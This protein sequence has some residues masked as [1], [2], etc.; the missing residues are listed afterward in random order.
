MSVSRSLRVLVAAGILAIPVSTL[1][2]SPDMS[3]LGAG[4]W[5][6]RG[7]VP[8]IPTGGPGWAVLEQYADRVLPPPNISDTDQSNPANII[9][10][11]K[12][13]YYARTGDGRYREE[14]IAACE[15]V[16]GTEVKGTTLELGRKLISYVLAAD[17]VGLPPESDRRFRE[18]LV[19]VLDEPLSDGRSLRQTHEERPN[20]W[21]TLAGASRVATAAYL[22]NA[23]EVARVATVFRGWLGD[24]QSYSGFDFKELDWQANPEQPV[25]INPAGS[26]KEGYS[27]DGVLPEEMRRSGPFRWPP[28]KENYVYTALQ[29]AVATAV[30]LTRAGYDAFDWQDKA[31]LRAYQWLVDQ[32]SYPAEG[33]D[34][35]IPFVINHYYGTSF[36]VQVGNDNAGKNVGFTEWTVD[37]NDFSVLTPIWRRALAD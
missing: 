33:N 14:V 2:A 9:V 29:G 19:Y 32:A 35:W 7:S 15:E 24:R 21:G 22:K 13:L 28:P 3:A 5:I 30:I 6:D 18:W 36:A 23:A 8:S 31:L 11:A 17:L 26:T 10:F 25:G 34:T 4:I 12:A 27:I 16:I 37:A 1:P 20:N